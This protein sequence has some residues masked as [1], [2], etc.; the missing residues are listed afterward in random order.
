MHPRT[1]W[2]CNLG[3]SRSP[4]DS[5]QGHRGPQLVGAGECVCGLW[6][7]NQVPQA[8]LIPSKG[9]EHCRDVFKAQDTC[10]QEKSYRDDH[11]S[12]VS[13][14]QTWLDTALTQ[15]V[16]T[17]LRLETPAPESD[18]TALW[19][20]QEAALFYSSSEVLLCSKV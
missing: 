15:G 11:L 5:Q 2:F 1:H 8:I 10:Q 17:L 13:G 16:F 6:V 20:S 7:F 4:P 3:A 19:G 18:V 9:G 14:S 12:E